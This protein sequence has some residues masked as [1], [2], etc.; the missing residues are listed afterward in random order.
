MVGWRR[1]SALTGNLNTSAGRSF[2]RIAL[3][4]LA[5]LIGAAAMVCPHA[6]ASTNLFKLYIGA[7]YG[8]A[9]I[10][11]IA[12]P[13]FAPPLSFDASHSGYQIIAGAR[14]LSLLGVELDYM[15]LGSAPATLR[16]PPVLGRITADD[17]QAA[18]K[19][20][21][22][23][24]VFYLPV[25]VIDIY[26]KA[27]IARLRTDLSGTLT[28]TGCNPFVACACPIGLNGPD[29]S[30]TLHGPIDTTSSGFAAAAGVQWQ[31][32]NWAVRGEYERFT[33][34]GGHPS[35]ASIGVTWAFL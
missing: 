18:E 24:A 27:G 5:A 13:A 1:V 9:D 31:F 6:E 34:L 20:E 4:P 10:E 23:F 2:A 21:A 28:A 25:P 11:G 22:A 12:S 32:G 8:H 14:I 35:L 15:D 29:C 33:A 3:L 26:L 30:F 17:M 19:G 7:A 16:F